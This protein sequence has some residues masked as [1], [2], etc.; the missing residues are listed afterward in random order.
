MPAMATMKVQVI[1]MLADRYATRRKPLQQLGAHDAKSAHLGLW[2]EKFIS[3]THREASEPA[4]KNLLDAAR[5]ILV[6]ENH[7]LSLEQSQGD[8]YDVFFERQ[9][10]ALLQQQATL[11][12][13]RTIARMVVGLGNESLLENNLC[14]HRTYGVPII[15]GSALKGLCSSFAH[16]FLGA[17]WQKGSQAHQA[18]FGDTSTQGYVTFFDALPLPQTWTLEREVMTVHHQDYYSGKEAAPPADWDDPNPIPFISASGTFL[19]A[20]HAPESWSGAISELLE[21]ALVHEG[22]GAK[23]SSGYGRLELNDSKRQ[24]QQKAALEQQ[25]QQS[26]ANL[27][28]EA[29][30][31]EIS[32]LKAINQYHQQMP[33]IVAKIKKLEPALQHQAAVATLALLQERKLSKE[34]K[35]RAWYKDLQASEQS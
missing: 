4:Q 7:R 26:N 31:T 25:K 10:N 13:A 30:L 9:K 21:V 32:K 18:A 28:L 14:L 19:L 22:V 20:F 15:P 5:K 33:A 8:L 12:Q 34:F 11:S 24:Q 35:D 17:D 23:T 3:T 16:R 6:E 29:V 2:L 27:A 1:R